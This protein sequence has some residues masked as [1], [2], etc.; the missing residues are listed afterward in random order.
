MFFFVFREI[1]GP[2][3]F[4]AFFWGYYSTC[5]MTLFF[6]P[7]PGVAAR[8][9]ASDDPI[10]RTTGTNNPQKMLKKEFPLAFH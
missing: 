3:P 1:A 7:A 5:V 9:D 6:E 4:W 10:Q 2:F 8:R